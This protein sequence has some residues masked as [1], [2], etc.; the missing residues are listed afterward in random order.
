MVV[1]QKDRE[2]FDLGVIDFQDAVYGP[3]T[4]D[5]VSILRDAYVSWDEAIQLEWAIQYWEL[6]KK[7]TIPV[8]NDF[9][10]FWRAFEWMGLQ[11]HLKILGIF[12]RLYYRDGK[13]NYLKDLPL[14]L[15]Y[16]RPVV[17]RYSIFMPLKKLLDRLENINTTV[18]YTF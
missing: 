1:S 12:A 11:R 17:S 9:S 4:Y 18:S 8:P 16:I 13:E 6:A 15:N 3:V 5:L 14:V 2:S 7:N 10:E